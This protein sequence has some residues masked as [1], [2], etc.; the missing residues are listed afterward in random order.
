[1]CKYLQLLLGTC[2]SDLECQ[3]C[4][5]WNDK[6]YWLLI[7]IKA[8]TFC[9]IILHICPDL[10]GYLHDTELRQWKINF[11]RTIK[12][13]KRQESVYCSKIIQ[14]KRIF[15]SNTQRAHHVDLTRILRRYVE[16]QIST[17]FHI[18]SIVLF[19]CNFTDQKIQVVSTYFFNVI[20]MV[21]KSTSFPRTFFRC[22]FD[23]GKI[24]VIS[25]YFFDVILLIE[26]SASFPRTFFDVISMVEKSKSFP[27]TF[28]EVT[29]MVQKSTLFPC[30]FLDVI[31]F[32]EISTVFLLTFFD[33]ILMVE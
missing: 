21:E 10:C 12:L 6:R 11:T 31:S 18:V 3:W 15:Q 2:Q 1:M 27:R 30:A 29:L 25:T 20:L 33:V 32:V 7:Y 28:F 26:K 5:N 13:E 19:Q 23:G 14:S 9:G 22:N 24:H 17:N 8:I 4:R 16:D